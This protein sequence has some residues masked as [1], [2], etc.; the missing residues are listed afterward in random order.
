MFELLYKAGV[1]LWALS[2][3]CVGR[4][5]P[6]TRTH[7]HA[8]AHT[9]AP[10]RTRMRAHANARPSH[11]QSHAHTSTVTMHT[12]LPMSFCSWATLSAAISTA[13][14]LLW[15]RLGRNQPAATP[16]AVASMQYPLGASAIAALGRVPAPTGTSLLDSP[17]SRLAR[18]KRE[19]RVKAARLVGGL[20]KRGAGAEARLAHEEHP[21]QR[22]QAQPMKQVCPAGVPAPACVRACLRVCVRACLQ[23]CL[24]GRRPQPQQNSA[25]YSA[26]YS[27]HPP[28]FPPRAAGLQL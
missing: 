23:A 17:Q 26:Q 27:A 21:M 16:T 10:A 8:H 4:P 12:R 7:V 15:L 22:L 18:F 3:G 1:P 11:Y 5:P 2:V 9:H 19:R 28:R 20:L 25:Q 14:L 6:R 24:P 13:L